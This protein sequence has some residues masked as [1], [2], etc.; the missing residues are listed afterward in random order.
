MA[1]AR[2]YKETINK[3]AKQDPE[4]AKAL[5]GEALTL[6]INGEPDVARIILRDFVNNVEFHT[7]SN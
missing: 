5:L 3:R 2:D 1:L 4:F 6:F 7:V